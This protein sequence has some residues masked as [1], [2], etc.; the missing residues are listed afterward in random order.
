M[1]EKKISH[2]P[3]DPK[4]SFI[5]ELLA[6]YLRE[7]PWTEAKD[8]YEDLGMSKS[9]FFNIK[10]EAG[11]EIIPS[12]WSKWRKALGMSKEAFWKRAQKRYDP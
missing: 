7:K 2:A 10:Y 5:Q 11:R 12:H 4:L 6:E 1:E 3:L 9:G 8:L